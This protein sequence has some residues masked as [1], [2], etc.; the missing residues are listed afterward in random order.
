MSELK[1]VL[2]SWKTL[3]TVI[4]LLVISIFIQRMGNG[5]SQ[6]GFQQLNAAYDIVLEEVKQV[7]PENQISYL[8]NKSNEMR[9]IFGLK[10]RI[11]EGRENTEEY[12]LIREEYAT[13]S[14]ELVEEIEN[15]KIDLTSSEANDRRIAYSQM[16]DKVQYVGTYNN[17]YEKI[18]SE[19]KKMFSVSIFS[20][21]NS[22]SYRNINKTVNDFKPI[23]SWKIGLANTQVEDSLFD[24][25]LMDYLLLVFVIIL[26]MSFLQERKSS[27]WTL[28]Y[29]SAE[30]RGTLALRRIVVLFLGSS[31]MTVLLFVTKVFVAQNEFG[32]KINFGLPLQSISKF[33][34]VPSAITLGEFFLEY[35]MVRIVTIFFAGLLLWFILSLARNLT[36]AIALTVLILAAQYG[37]FVFVSDS[38]I[39]A[40]SKF[41][42]FFTFITPQKLFEKYLNINIMDYPINIKNLIVMLLP[43]ITVLLCVLLVIY[44]KNKRPISHVSKIEVLLDSLRIKINP[45]LSKLGLGGMELY[46]TLLP[47]KGWVV[48]ILFLYLMNGY[49]GVPSTF[50]EAKDYVA[51][52]Y[53]NV[54][55][56]PVNEKTLSELRELLQTSEKPVQVDTLQESNPDYY[57]GVSLVLADAERI[58]E[59]NRNEGKELELIAPYAYQS[60]LGE[61]SERYHHLQGVKFVLIIVLLFSG[62]FVYEK[63]KK[64]KKLILS[65]REGRDQFFKKKIMVNLGLLFLLFVAFY[66]VEILSAN[67]VMGGFMNLSAPA[68]SL[69]IFEGLKGNYSLGFML[70]YL[71]LVRMLGCILLFSLI[72][73]LSLAFSKVNHSMIVMLIL[74]VLPMAL[75]DIGGGMLSKMTWAFFLN[76]LGILKMGWWSPIAMLLL[77]I[78]ISLSLKVVFKKD[79]KLL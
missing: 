4:V 28:V 79:Y 29:A 56:G 31:V 75:S 46:K 48:I 66:G 53:Y 13:M 44:H 61:N 70:A 76:S 68:R 64:M 60:L 47:L 41:L 72:S 69:T 9:V 40:P 23:E 35:L 74:F 2:F 65:S 34:F 25:E 49:Q 16:V 6:E 32:R 50:V 5:N 36:I 11:E 55:Q 45:I 78:S 59:I 17:Y 77:T 1:R 22:F 19:A 15:G 12:L 33:R 30:G 21:K 10:S 73:L 39:L 38:S 51:L 3:F 42:N 54:Y 26:V 8:E 58:D 67:Q 37:L 27:M 63:E 57:E 62:V 20:D 7:N 71:Y 24:S 14:P 18:T 52:K 43:F